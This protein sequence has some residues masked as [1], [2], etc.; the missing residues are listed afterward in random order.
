MISVAGLSLSEIRRGLRT[1]T[2]GGHIVLYGEVDSTNARLVE[3]ARGGA[4]HGTVV[5]ADAQTAG[6]GRYGRAWFSPP[7]VN[8]YISVLLR[9]RLRARDLG[10]FS[11]IASLALA[12]RSG[13][14][15][16]TR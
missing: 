3:L 2:V 10:V 16:A 8:A 14:S 1:E 11:L 6:R 15:G 12:V 9:P 7:G 5:L 13:T 4:S